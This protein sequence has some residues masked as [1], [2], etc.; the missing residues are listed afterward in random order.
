[1]EDRPIKALLVEDDPD[2]AYLLHQ[3]LDEAAPGQIGLVHVSRLTDALV[4]LAGEPFDAVLLDLSLPDSSG[5]DTFV[6]LHRRSPEVAVVV[7]TGLDDQR[8]AMMAVSDGAQDYLVKGKVEGSLLVRSLRYAI[9][10]QRNTHYRSLLTERERFDTAVSLM[11]DGIVVTA[12]DW[13]I[14]NANRAA[15]LLLNLAEGDWDGTPLATALESFALSVPFSELHATHDRA[16]A[17]Q[18]SRPD[19]RPPLYVDAR[20]SRLFDA[21]GHLVSTVLMLR[22]VTDSRLVR[23]VQANFMSMVPHKLRTPISVLNGY[24]QIAKMLTPAE[25]GAEWGQI[26]EAWEREVR[27]LEGIVEKLLDFESVSASQLEEEMQETDL[28]VVIRSS[29]RDIRRRYPDKD[30]EVATEIPPGAELVGCAPDHL[31]FIL[32]EVLDNAAKFGD[33]E[34]VRVV[35]HTERQPDGG[36]AFRVSDNG[37]GIPHEYFDRIF[38]GFVQVEEYCTGQIPGLGIGL[39]LAR[40][41]LEACG[42]TIGLESQIGE[43]SVFRITLPPPPA[44]Q[45]LESHI[46]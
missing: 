46:T 35:V 18:V 7:L 3:I 23:S 19:T 11:S 12:G 26:L 29:V 34:T 38:E 9:E 15:C 13:R 4:R 36:L 16:T 43:G 39:S 41:V 32:C 37:P 10:R 5:I 25:L 30:I 20:L 24:L 17:F 40:K 21:N 31:R 14:T 6:E 27:R 2:D 42:G 33:K 44:T 28:G 1:M 45:Y 8:V 22:D